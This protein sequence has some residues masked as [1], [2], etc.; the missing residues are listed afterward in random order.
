MWGAL[1]A[2]RGGHLST[3]AGARQ[4][5][6]APGLDW[7]DGGVRPRR[8]G[9]GVRD[10]RHEQLVV[11]QPVSVKPRRRWLMACRSGGFKRACRWVLHCWG[12]SSVRAAC[13]QGH[14]DGG[15]PLSLTA[16]GAGLL[17]LYDGTALTIWPAIVLLLA[18]LLA[19]APIFA[20]LGGL[21][22]A[23]FWQE[24]TP[25]AAHCPVALSDH[26]QS[27][28]ARAAL[29][30]AGRT[31]VRTHGGGAKAG[32]TVRRPV[33]PRHDRHGRGRCGAVLLLHGPDRWQ[34]G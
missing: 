16:C 14:C 6:Q 3:L 5:A 27:L 32:A 8:G 9:A 1:A 19:G 18:A 31:G 30:H 4:P 15:S 17:S 28:P 33:W 2:E 24:G 12:S 7:L 10:A 20:V 13:P 22:L 29:I 34:W 26:G 11:G 21:A 25:L 23:L